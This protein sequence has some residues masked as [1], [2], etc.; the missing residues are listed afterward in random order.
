M[1]FS[2]SD[3]LCR[4]RGAVL[5]VDQLFVAQKRNNL[6]GIT[7]FSKVGIVVA[8]S[9]AG[10]REVVELGATNIILEELDNAVDNFGD[11]ISSLAGRF[12]C[13]RGRRIDPSTSRRCRSSACY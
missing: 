6:W 3:T 10:S 1:S 13:E 5:M 11:P 9:H 8:P 7:A 2:Q 12:T 4:N